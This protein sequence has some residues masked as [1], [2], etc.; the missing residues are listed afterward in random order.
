MNSVCIVV[1]L[2]LYIRGERVVLRTGTH[3]ITYQYKHLLSYLLNGAEYYLK[4][5]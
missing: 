3:N 5:W 1:C 4:S 2:C